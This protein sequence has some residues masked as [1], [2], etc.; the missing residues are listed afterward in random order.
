MCGPDPFDRPRERVRG[1][2]D[3]RPQRAQPGRVSVVDIQDEKKKR[4]PSTQAAAPRASPSEGLRIARGDG[5]QDG[6]VVRRRAD[7]LE[8]AAMAEAQFPKERSIHRGLPKEVWAE[9]SGELSSRL[10]DETREPRDTVDRFAPT[11]RGPDPQ[12]SRLCH[13][14][15]KFRYKGFRFPES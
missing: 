13:V 8:K 9:R 7:D 15:L 3:C 4:V 12:V 10:I 2:G 5:R 1:E 11:P 14:F 6:I